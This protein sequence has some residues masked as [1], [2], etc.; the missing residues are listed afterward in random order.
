MPTTPAAPV[1]RSAT[2]FGLYLAAAAVAAALP[3]AR[4][5]GDGQTLVTCIVLVV[6]FA[7]GAMLVK[8]RTIVHFVSLVAAAHL[9]ILTGLAAH[10]ALLAATGDRV[11]ATVTAR[12]IVKGPHHAITYRYSLRTPGHVPIPGGLLEDSDEF[13][14]GD[15]VEVVTNGRVNPKTTGEVAAARPLGIAAAVALV[16]TLLSCLAIGRIFPKEPPPA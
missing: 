5:P 13:G 16:A 4:L 12:A 3:L 11:T 15:T 8:S 7:A 9:V 14:V 1:A 6:A 2:V 10:S